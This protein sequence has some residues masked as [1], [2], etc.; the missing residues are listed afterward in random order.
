MKLQQLKSDVPRMPGHESHFLANAGRMQPI[1]DMIYGDE[2]VTLASMARA[3]MP[4]NV[5]LFCGHDRH[6]FRFVE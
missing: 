2:A 1:L 5:L 3:V 4:G 6:F